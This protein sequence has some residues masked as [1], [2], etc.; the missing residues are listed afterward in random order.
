MSRLASGLQRLRRSSS[1]WEV[2]WS[3][4]ASCGLVLFSQLA[5]A[6][7][8]R[9][10]PFLSLLAMLP[11]AGL[12]FI[13]AIVLGRLWRRFIGVAASAPLFVLFNILLLW[14]VYVFVIRRETSSL[15][16]M[17]IN[18]ECALLLWGFYRILSGDP[19]IVACDSSYL[20]EAGCKD[21]VEAIYSSEKLPMLSRV[22]QC[23]WCKANIRGYDH[24]CPAFGTCI[25][26]KNHRLFMALLTG[27]VVAEST[28]TM[29]STKYI[30][31]CISSGTIRSEN[32]VSLNIVISTT[33]FSILQV[34]WQIVFLMWHIYCICFN[35]KT[36]E[37][38]NWKKYPEFQMK[39]QPRSDSEVKFVNPYDKGMLCNI[40]EFLK[41]E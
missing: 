18:A 21:F 19:G 11:I 17:L 27:F 34:L 3:A 35:I 9:L 40:R 29:C 7:V 8:P 12:V 6:M 22:R 41:P 30:T 25:G 38:I 13:A 37:W 14:G 33:L 31:R 26:Q 32:P 16:D 28:Y 23:T 4:L 10:F 24:H 1:Q 5:V 2:L 15:L 39:E 36:D 20:E